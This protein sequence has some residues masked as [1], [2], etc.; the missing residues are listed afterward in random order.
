MIAG[1]GRSIGKRRSPIERTEAVERLAERV[2]HAAEPALADRD[3]HHPAFAHRLVAGSQKQRVVAEQ[4][5][6]DLVGV[7]IERDARHAAGEP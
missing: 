4:H 7:D 2:D 6:A 5:D 1:A 3:V